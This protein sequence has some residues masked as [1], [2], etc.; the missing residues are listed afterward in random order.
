MQNLEARLNCRL[1]DRLGRLILPTAAA[2]MLYP[3]AIAILEDLRRL[4]ADINS[5][6]NV[7]SGK[8][9]IGASTIPGTYILPP[10]A[11]SFKNDFPGISFEIRIND[12]AKIAEAVAE[13][14]LF[15][16]VVGAKISTAKL[17]YQPLAEDELLLTVAGTNPVPSE[18]TM[19]ELCQLP[20]IVRE[21]GSGTRK[22]LESLLTRQHTNLDQL[23]IC[24]TLGS[25]AAVKEA[26]KADLGVSVLSRHAVQD[27]LLSGTIKEIVVTDLM[28]KRKIYVVTSPKRTL[29]NHYQEFRKR[30][31]DSCTCPLKS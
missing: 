25:S 24:A 7:I 26:V 12:S 17:S 6:G 4:E 18:I 8:L 16:G 10:V 13:N 3:R 1:F 9:I 2:L 19:T 29:P 20:F 15:L 30:L 28:M 22:S 27:E 31:F 21:R 23:N 11:A 14:E 5:A